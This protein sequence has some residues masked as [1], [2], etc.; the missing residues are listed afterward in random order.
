ME[1]RTSNTSVDS[2]AAHD[3][4]SPQLDKRLQHAPS[5]GALAAGAEFGGTGG[6]PKWR[7][8]N[9]MNSSSFAR[10]G[11]AGRQVHVEHDLR[12]ERGAQAS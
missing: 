4:H 12:G 10:A 9:A 2:T 6:G 8:E 11:G 5:V 1:S 7:L 3:N